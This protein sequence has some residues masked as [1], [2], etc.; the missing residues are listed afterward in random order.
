MSME[1]I[2]THYYLVSVIG[3]FLA[4]GVFLLG[5]ERRK[6]QARELVTL[7]VMSGIAVA[8]RAAFIMIPF[9]KPMTGIIM[10]TGMA[11]GGGA[12]FLVGAV[13]AFVSNFIF[14]QRSEEPHV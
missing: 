14:G 4:F 11:F 5:F 9:F 3:I 2:N 7:A 13:S 10:I 12:G 6:P 1:L 8:S